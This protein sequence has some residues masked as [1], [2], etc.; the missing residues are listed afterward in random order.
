MAEPEKIIVQHIV[1]EKATEATSNLNQYTFK[2]S[3]SSNR[4][5]VKAAV[6]RQFGV[7]VNSVNILNV[8][9]KFKRDRSR[10]GGVGRKPGFKKAIIRLKAGDTIDLV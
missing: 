7:T 1:T 2:V 6:E 8:K 4:V 9:P 10:R 3:K 5:S